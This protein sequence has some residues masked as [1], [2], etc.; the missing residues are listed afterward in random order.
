MAAAFVHETAI[1]DEGAQLGDGTKVWHF[2]HVMGGAVIGMGCSLGQNV[3]VADRVTIG[4]RVK[5]QNNVSVYDGVSLEDG[6]FC[7]PST[8]FTNV[9]NPRAEVE[10]KDEYRPT[11]VRRGATLGANCTIICGT[12]IGQWAF[13]AAGAVVTDDV[14]AH[15]L[16]IGVPARQ[17]GWVC[18]CGEQ[19]AVGDAEQAVCSRCHRAFR[20]TDGVFVQIAGDPS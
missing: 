13:V 11:L 19:L 6:V 20:D 16:V 12:T 18:T 15:A 17:R 10:R 8:V 4:D 9:L 2:T 14:A 7:G 1:V 3:F 5:V